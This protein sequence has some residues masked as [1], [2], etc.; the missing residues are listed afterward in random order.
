LKYLYNMKTL[1]YVTLSNTQVTRKGVDDLKQAIPK[2]DVFWNSR[3]LQLP[4]AE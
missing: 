1:Q 4:K 2:A 3:H